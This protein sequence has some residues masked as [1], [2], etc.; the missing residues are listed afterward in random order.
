MGFVK[1]IF[2]DRLWLSAA[3]VVVVL[4]IAVS[5]MFAEVLDTPL[6]SRPIDVDISLE[7]TGGLFEGSAVTYRGVKVGKVTSIL[8][9][10]DAG[11]VVASV[12]ISAGTEIPA[13][14]LA[15]V[16]SLS[17]VGEQYLDFQ[18]NTTSAPFLKDG[19]KIG[20]EATDLPKSLSSTV[21]AVNNLLRQ[22]DDKKL[23]IVL[24]ELSTGMAGTGDDLGLVIDQGGELLKVLEEIWPETDRLITNSETV[25]DVITDNATTLRELGTSAKQFAAFLKDY[26][27]EFRE[28]LKRTPGYLED[29]EG[30]IKDTDEYLP[31][32]LQTSASFSSMFRPWNPHLRTLL[33][34]Y[35]RGIAALNSVIH[36]GALNLALRTTRTARCDYGNTRH[37]STQTGTSFQTGGHCGASFGR[38]QRGAA[39]APGPVR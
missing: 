7:Q 24:K 18:P 34:E 25:L 15:R 38:L 13:D 33:Q 39:H 31:A 36:G 11:G 14:S 37:P 6:T 8:P 9:A 23:R 12:R 19:A 1:R 17:P 27:P 22:I 20:A 16:R 26:T 32:F 4:A 29:L 30:V 28:V 35:P 10:K 3:G 5:Y 21:V 2:T